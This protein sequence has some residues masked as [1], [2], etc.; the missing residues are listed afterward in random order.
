MAQAL[1]DD[2]AA[3]VLGT[4]FPLHGLTTLPQSA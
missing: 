3:V 2:R 4:G 1:V